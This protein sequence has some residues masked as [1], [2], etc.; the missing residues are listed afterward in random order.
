MSDGDLMYH[1]YG[2]VDEGTDWRWLRQEGSRWQYRNSD[3]EIVFGSD[4][5]DGG[6]GFI[7]AIERPTP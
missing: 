5:T 4:K 7:L 3:G 6:P 2:F 1:T